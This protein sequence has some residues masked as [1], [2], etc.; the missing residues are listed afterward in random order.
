MDRQ[1]ILQ[2]WWRLS[3]MLQ[4]AL[5]RVLPVALRLGFQIFI[6]KQE[7][8]AM[9]PHPARHSPPA[10]GSIGRRLESCGHRRSGGYAVRGLHEQKPL[11]LGD[12]L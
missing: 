4:Q 5:A 12:T 3:S 9:L 1:A 8:T 6:R 7:S 11:S 10:Y 2:N